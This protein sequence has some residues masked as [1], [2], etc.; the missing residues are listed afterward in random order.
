MDASTIAA[1]PKAVLHDHL[2]GGLRVDTVVE[3]ADAVGHR[4]PATDAPTLASW[5]HQ[6]R[7]GSLERYLAAFEHTIAVMQ[8]PEAVRRVAR[9]A[10]EDLASDGVVY[11]EVRFDPGL[12]VEQA[13][14]REEVIEAALDGFAEASADREIDIHTIVCALRDRHDSVL[15]A[16]A[17]ARY[18]G[19]GVVGFDLA[20]PEVGFP[21]DAHRRAITIAREA[22]LGVT[23]HAGEAD[24]PHSI[25]R[26]RMLCGADRIGHGVRIADVTDFDG[27]RLTVLGP[28]AR[29]IRDQRVPL[30]MAIS[31]NVDTGA[32]ETPEAHPFGALYRAGFNVTLNT[33]N[34]L[35]SGVTVSSEYRLASEVFGLGPSDLG[36]ITTAAIQAGFGPWDQRRRLIEGVVRPAYSAV[37]GAAV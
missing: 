2:D 19:R 24:G 22:G 6:A 33:D 15:A 26:A 1:L 23:L 13:M 30:E 29:T 7:S 31:S 9:E 11:A 37:E 20:G 18:V 36:A 25:W 34:R 28:F 10:A 35:M 21:P 3:L 12:F 17:A 16:T 8:S 14:S 32:Y 4:L 27:S 5:F